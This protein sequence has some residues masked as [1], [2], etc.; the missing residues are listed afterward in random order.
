MRLP[1]HS[2]PFPLRLRGGQRTVLGVQAWWREQAEGATRMHTTGGPGCESCPTAPDA[3]RLLAIAASL[4]LVCRHPRNI[5]V[6]ATKQRS[7]L[8]ISAGACILNLAC[9]PGPPRQ[10]RASQ[11]HSL[12][13]L[14]AFAMRSLALVALGLVCLATALSGPSHHTWPHCSPAGASSQHRRRRPRT[15]PL[16]GRLVYGRMLMRHLL[17][18]F[19][20]LCRCGCA[21]RLRKL[22]RL[23][24]TH[25]T[26]TRRR[27][28]SARRFGRSRSSR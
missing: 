13:S 21:V 6:C 25:S 2:P 18:S 20:F 22:Q 12:F 24:R 8:L 15:N 26:A 4:H 28:A 23:V 17:C 14:L 1:A 5:R 16:R 9:A 10:L 3:A 27:G 19:V 7:I 11:P